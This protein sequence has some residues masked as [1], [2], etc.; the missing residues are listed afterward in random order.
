M[1]LTNVTKVIIAGGR[2]FD[3]WSYLVNASMNTLKH[4]LYE[5]E[6]DVMVFCGKAKG[7]DTLGERFAKIHNFEV[8]E[9][10]ADWDTHGKKAGFLRNEEMAREADMLIAFW[11]GE[12]KGTKNMIDN[13][14]KYGLETH[15]FFY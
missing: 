11:D 10:P 7:A 13:A 9:F 6:Y 14:L 8:K 12:S 2:D 4:V 3:D 5:M 1:E 15:I